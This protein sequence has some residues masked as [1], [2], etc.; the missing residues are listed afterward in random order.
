MPVFKA[1]WKNAAGH[2]DATIRKATFKRKHPKE[3][4]AGSAAKV[5]RKEEGELQPMAAGAAAAHVVQTEFTEEVPVVVAIS[6]NSSS[7][8]N[9]TFVA[10]RALGPVGPPHEI[11]YYKNIVHHHHLLYGAVSSGSRRRSKFK[12]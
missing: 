6:R 2:H 9:F 7:R 3:V 10:D 12:F 4:D 8:D 5:P 1:A 11:S